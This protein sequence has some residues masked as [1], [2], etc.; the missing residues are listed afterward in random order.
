MS[1]EQALDNAEKATD[2]MIGQF[3]TQ[4]NKS[5]KTDAEKPNPYHYGIGKSHGEIAEYEAKKL[6]EKYWPEKSGREL[7]RHIGDIVKLS[8]GRLDGKTVREFID[9]GVI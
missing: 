6:V 3:T 9:E 5:V 8:H 4:M 2:T 7:F 1:L